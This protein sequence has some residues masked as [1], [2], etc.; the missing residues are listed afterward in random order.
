MTTYAPVPA[1]RR[2]AAGQG[3][4]WITEAFGLFRDYPASWVALAAVFLLVQLGLGLIPLIGQMVSVLS[5]PPLFAGALLALFRGERGEAP[6]VTDLFACCQGERI[7]P[8]FR[9]GVWYLG[10][11]FLVYLILALVALGGSGMAQVTAG[12]P[13][14]APSLGMALL[15]RLALVSLPATFLLMLMFWLAPLLTLRHQLSPAQ[16][17]RL[18][19]AA[20]LQNLPAFLVYFFM[21]T[22]LAF[23]AALPFGLGLLVWLPLAMISPWTCYR[24]VFGEE[25]MA[26]PE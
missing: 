23:L 10:V 16:A 12:T 25:R 15:W 9:L 2:V 13:D 19:T 7:L 11:S 6:R 21:M 17:I 18:G 1:P 26:L 4:R 14:A 20:A 22:M 8:F 5:V 3:W 24:D